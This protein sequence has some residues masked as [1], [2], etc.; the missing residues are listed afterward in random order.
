MSRR[1]SFAGPV[2]ALVATLLLLTVGLL[3]IPSNPR[4]AAAKPAQP[5][6]A[7]DLDPAFGTGGVVTTPFTTT[8]GA[9]ANALVATLDGKYIIAAAIQDANPNLM[10]NVSLVCYNADGSVDSSF[11]I[12]GQ[13]TTD[14]TGNSG[15]AALAVQSD[16]KIVLMA[17]LLML[18]SATSAMGY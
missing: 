13:V 10:E 6:R 8:V 17:A 14:F 16:G 1:A 12:G 15:S 11:G 18:S 9:R 2:L 3:S 4:P 7:G 5:A